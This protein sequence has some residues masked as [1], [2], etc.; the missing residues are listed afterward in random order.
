MRCPI[1]TPENAELLLAYCSRKLDPAP[2]AILDDHIEICPACREFARNQ[3]AVWKALDAWEA[4]P[5]SSDFDRR[6]YQRIEQNV[7]WW[8]R[9]IR[10][11]RPVLFTKGLPITAAAAVLIVAGVL[12]ERP[13]AIPP[14]SPAEMFAPEQVEQA[15]EEMELIR[16]FGE[17]LRPEGSVPRL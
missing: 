4:A 13:S 1:E 14:N 12:L 6:L 15:L 2:A 5:V 11:V 10:P 8:E 7:S 3:Q 16:Q 9:I 17:I